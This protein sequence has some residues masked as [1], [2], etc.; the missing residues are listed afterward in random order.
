MQWWYVIHI[1]GWVMSLILVPVLARRYSPAKAFGWLA[2]MFAIPWVGIALFL[3]LGD[4][5]LGRR[6]IARYRQVL[7]GST[8]ADR[9]TQIA[10]RLPKAELP[11]PFQAISRATEAS[12]ALPSEPGNAVEFSASHEQTLQ[13]LVRDIDAAKHHVHLVFYII[14]DDVVGQ[15]VAEAL[16][17]AAQRGVAC[18]IVA[19]AFGSRGVLHGQFARR[20]EKKGIHVVPAM[21]FH[22]LKGPLA[23]LDVRNHRKIAV[24]DGLVGYIGSW[25]IVDPGFHPR[26]KG[27][28]HDLMARV[29]GQ[30]VSHLQL[31]FLEDWTSETREALSL[32]ELLVM[33]EVAGETVTQL[34]PS[35]PLYPFPP[36]RDMT[37]AM[38][39]LARRRVILTTPYFI[40]DEAVLLALRLAAQRGVE[41]NVIVPTHSDSRLAGAAGRA[42][43][44]ELTDMKVRV[45][46]Y[47]AGFLHVKSMTVDD[48][49]GMVGSANFDIRSFRLDIEANLVLYTAATVKT[50]REI[51]DNYLANS[52]PFSVQWGDRGW[53]RRLVDMSAK[54]VSPLA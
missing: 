52:V 18:R 39:G 14:R 16:E 22:P 20:L 35:G 11:P 31:L 44:A 38:L 47:N 54:L 43:S 13:W 3:L 33:P 12:G 28:Y 30:A 49:I 40:P 19:D 8:A 36:V 32:D 51:Q 53:L 1:S 9:L 29:Q 7:D 48:E 25:N 23:R 26:V 34:V 45:H 5:P 46:C 4:N 42:F 24:I 17:R 2:V 41:V 21:R 10:L 6:R 50:L 27:L 37:L 15:C